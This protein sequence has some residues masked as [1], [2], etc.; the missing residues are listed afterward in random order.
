MKKLEFYMTAGIANDMDND[1]GFACEIGTLIHRYICNDWGELCSDDYFMNKRA[2]EE[3]GR[4]LAVYT[5]SKGRVYIITDDTQ[6]DPKITTI[7][8]A[9]EY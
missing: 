6:A 9:D 7:L 4:I 5:T 2:L 8:Y 1:S 3:G